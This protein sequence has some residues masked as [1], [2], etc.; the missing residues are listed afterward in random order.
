MNLI[1]LAEK[2]RISRETQNT[3]KRHYCLTLL[4]KLIYLIIAI[5]YNLCITSKEQHV[6]DTYAVKQLSSAA[7]DV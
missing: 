6:L 3:N 7:T 1:G 5:F 4:Y 2:T